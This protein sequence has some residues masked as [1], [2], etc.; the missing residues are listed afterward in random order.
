MGD[1]DRVLNGDLD[2]F[3]RAYLMARRKGT[4]GSAPEAGDDA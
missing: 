4:L 3:I 2:P 1:V